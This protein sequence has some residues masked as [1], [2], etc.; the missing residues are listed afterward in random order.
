MA[1]SRAPQSHFQ[2]SLHWC[3]LV[4]SILLAT[5]HDIQAQRPSVLFIGDSYTNQN[6]LPDIFQQVAL[7]LGDTVN[8]GMSAPN[9]FSLGLHGS[10]FGN[11]LSLLNSQHWD[12]VVVQERNQWA[13]LF[14]VGGSSAA[15]WSF[16]QII[17]NSDECTYPVFFMTWGWEYGDPQECPNEPTLCTYEGMQQNLRQGIVDLAF[18]TDTWVAPV[19]VAWARVR[20][21]HPS[22]DLYQADG[23]H[24]S[25][26]GTYLA[27]CVF[28]CSLLR[29][30]CV[31][32]PYTASLPTSTAAILQ[33]VASST[34]LDS[35]DTWNLNL[36]NGTDATFTYNELENGVFC[37][38]PGMG[39]HEWICSNGESYTTNDPT[40]SFNDLGTYLITHYYS[41]P[42]GNS[43]S[44]SV[45]FDFAPLGVNGLHE[46]GNCPYQLTQVSPSLLEVIGGTGKAQFTLFDV[47]GR[48]LLEQQLG[49]GRTLVQCP[50]GPVVWKI[51]DRS[52]SFC[53]GVIFVW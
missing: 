27:A 20:N 22:I 11:A 2:H 10:G 8:I 49:S 41:D 1:T 45:S 3:A 26:E 25:V 33:Q 12:H 43:D 42:C 52:R 28:Y 51:S 30:T 48:V 6:D 16:I 29:G 38:H 19:G 44:A 14:P 36:P 7:S 9:G 46:L 50:S 15:A 40:F 39:T 5:I 17:E 24:P 13:A 4:V 32:A 47:Q 53:R 18:D 37:Y 21:D 34:V 31:G 35:V 23:S